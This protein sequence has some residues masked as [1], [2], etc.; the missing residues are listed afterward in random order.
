MEEMRYEKEQQPQGNIP[1]PIALLLDQ[2]AAMAK[3]GNPDAK[4]TPPSA[5][6]GHY[7]HVYLWDS[8]FS[9]KTFARHGY[10]KEAVEEMETVFE[11][12]LENGFIP[13]MQFAPNGRTF[14]P[15]RRTFMNP[16]DRSDY[17]QPPLMAETIL[18]IHKAHIKF[19]R[20]SEA[21][22]LLEKFYP[23]L[24]KAYDFFK[25]ERQNSPE[26]P[27]IGNIHP[28]ETGRDSDPTFDFIKLR[29]SRNGAKTSQTVDYIN[30]ALDYA[31]IITYNVRARMK[32]WDTEKLREI[33]WVNDVMFNTMYVKNLRALADISA[34]LGKY[35]DEFEYRDL[36]SK[37]EEQIL[38]QMW[39]Q[40]ARDGNGAFYA[41]DKTASQSIPA[42]EHIQRSNGYTGPRDERIRE[43][44]ISNLFPLQLE[45]LPLDKLASCLSLI[46]KSFYT[47]SP[48]P[49]VPI[50]S[51]HYDP[52]YQ[53][54]NMWRGPTW[55]WMNDC[56][57]EALA[58][59]A[60]RLKTGIAN[61]IFTESEALELINYCDD[62]SKWIY[63]S[64]WKLTKE[65]YAEFYDPFTGEPKRTVPFSGSA[66]AP[67]ESTF[68]L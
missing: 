49:T 60:S 35:E 47:F 44:T 33:F 55:I 18:E 24:T 32:K 68:G 57:A 30:T 54:K 52:S 23:N 12:Q 28:H 51:P 53:Q 58:M 26:D 40:D 5:I 7:P 65:S 8:C 6:D 56:I 64:S 25:N 37:V 16:R 48:L 22:E 38:T 36:V 15:E 27:L 66:I 46:S 45:N 11:G 10:T 43:I 14:D 50:D 67:T 34:N 41:L 3:F 31:S 21:R 2:R 59:Q 19:G 63:N 29:L 9:A 42:I 20:D 61:N 39:D 13:N 62:Y 17:T 1:R 4:H